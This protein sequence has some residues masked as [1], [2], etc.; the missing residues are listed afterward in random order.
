[1]ISKGVECPTFLWTCNPLS[2]C[3][4]MRFIDY[5]GGGGDLLDGLHDL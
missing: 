2:A 3:L 1:M 4:I 5:G